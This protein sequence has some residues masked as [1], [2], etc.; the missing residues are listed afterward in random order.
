MKK[1]QETQFLGTRASFTLGNFTKMIINCQCTLHATPHRLFVL[2]SFNAAQCYK[3]CNTKLNRRTR[4]KKGGRGQSVWCFHNYNNS[5][6]ASSW[7]KNDVEIFLH[8]LNAL[9]LLFLCICRGE[10]NF[11]G[12]G[13]SWEAAAA[14][15][16]DGKD[17]MEFLWRQSD[18]KCMGWLAGGINRYIHN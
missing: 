6:P 17:E 3:I 4:C 14:I 5:R 10:K 8:F 11:V 1:G 2:M 16:F 9:E 12:R 13:V 18:E 15:Y 7:G